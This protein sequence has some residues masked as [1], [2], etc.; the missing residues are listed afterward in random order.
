MTCRPSR[1]ESA[2]AARGPAGRFPAPAADRLQL[3]HSCRL[4]VSVS[5]YPEG[6]ALTTRRYAGIEPR[7]AGGPN[8]EPQAARLNV[9]FV[10]WAGT[11]RVTRGVPGY[12]KRMKACCPPGQ[13]C[14]APAG[15]E[16]PCLLWRVE[17]VDSPDANRALALWH[18][19]RSAQRSHRPSR[20]RRFLRRAYARA[21]DD[22]V[23]W[24]PHLP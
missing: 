20:E 4:P 6:I 16:E 24:R 11:W 22:A 8:A 2:S 19:F 14:N 9:R 13:G 17:R 23:P 21:R 15:R 10:T 7:R 1:R 18:R 3:L 12:P 5:A